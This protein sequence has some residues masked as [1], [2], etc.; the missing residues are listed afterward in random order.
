MSFRL[1]RPAPNP[2]NPQT[3]LAFDLGHSANVSLKVYDVAGRLVREL[4]VNEPFG[5]GTHQEIWNGRDGAGRTVASG[6]YI[7]WMEIGGEVQTQR[8]VLLK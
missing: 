1:H 3:T 6:S 5:E 7:A 2:F 8:M 4:L